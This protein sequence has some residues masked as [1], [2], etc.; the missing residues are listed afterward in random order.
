[1]FRAPAGAYDRFLGRYSPALAVALADFAGVE[2]GMRALDVGCGPGALTAVLAAR[3]GAENVAAVDPSEPFVEACRARIAG[4]DVALAAAEALPFGDA[5]FD[6][7][8]TQLVINFISD[9][10]AAVRELARVTR[11]GG[12][13]AACVWDYGGEMT[14]LR[15]FWESDPRALSRSPSTT[16]GSAPCTMRTAAGSA[17]GRSRSGSRRAPGRSRARRPERPCARSHS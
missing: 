1:M 5:A 7:V 11:P 9:P 8:L 14:L 3:L 17:W 4:A 6:A 16:N 2:P 15:T 10:A 12:V 13:V